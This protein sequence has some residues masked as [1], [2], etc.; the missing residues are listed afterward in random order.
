MY[1]NTEDLHAARGTTPKKRLPAFRKQEDNSLKHN[2]KTGK[3]G[4]GS[5]HIHEKD[6][7]HHLSF[8]PKDGG[9]A[10]YVGGHEDIR[11]LKR[12]V[13]EFKGVETKDAKP[14]EKKDQYNT[15]ATVI[16]HHP[17]E[18]YERHEI[19]TT[20]EEAEMTGRSDQLNKHE[21]K[22]AYVIPLPP[23]K[24]SGDILDPADIKP[25]EYT[26]EEQIATQHPGFAN[27]QNKEEF[28]RGW[29]EAKDA[30]RSG[31][32][33]DDVLSGISTDVSSGGWNDYLSGGQAGVSHLIELEEE[34][35]A[36]AIDAGIDG[37]KLVSNPL[38]ELSG[39]KRHDP[40]QRKIATGLGKT[41][42]KPLTRSQEPAK[43]FGVDTRQTFKE[44]ETHDS[45]Q[46]RLNQERL[47]IT[48]TK[49]KDLNPEPGKKL[50]RDFSPVR[51]FFLSHPNVANLPEDK[52]AE[53][54]R[55]LDDAETIYQDTRS[56]PEFQRKIAHLNTG[57]ETLYQSTI[58]TLLVTPK[59]TFGTKKTGKVKPTGV[60]SSRAGSS[61]IMSKPLQVQRINVDLVNAGL[62]P[63]TN[64]V[65][66]LIDD[67]LSLREN[68][69]NVAKQLGYT[70]SAR[71]KKEAKEAA[72]HHQCISAQE[73]CESGKDPV[74]CSEY[75]AG[76][77]EKTYGVVQPVIPV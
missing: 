27:A 24:K 45:R 68:R 65:D 14:K 58:R 49:K 56:I 55:A 72:I 7:K 8:V 21:G 18:E 37:N 51:T 26:D 43:E 63:E 3:H 19:Y 17:G 60:R 31:Q 54:S 62:D 23:G 22:R 5:Y 30:V 53:I 10:Q 70:Y 77:C 44:N 6:G 12:M 73:R 66:S 28:L 2:T 34:A 71:S 67:T 16:V 59:E 29:K 4:A 36:E 75:V 52:K 13:A 69:T 48:S 38:F 61:R 9:T 39:D 50:K 1:Y 47:G 76:G 42:A 15:H 41:N 25:R 33:S 57:E 32:S 74:A 35:E 46:D 40:D 64:D 11:E 20:G